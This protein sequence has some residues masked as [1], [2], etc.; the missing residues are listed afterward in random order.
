MSN[1]KEVKIYSSGPCNGPSLL[2]WFK[3]TVDVVT[4]VQHVQI[5]IEAERCFL[6]IQDTNSGVEGKLFLPLKL[7][8]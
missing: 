5:H 8:D 2:L 6:N 4:P 3:H 1:N 7:T